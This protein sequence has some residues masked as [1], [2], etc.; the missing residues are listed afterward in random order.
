MTNANTNTGNLNPPF[1]PA[2]HY[3]SA[4]DVLNDNGLSVP[5]KR[6]ILSSWASDI[7]A[8]ESCPALREIPG[9]GHTIGLADI[10]AALRKLDGDD[11]DPPR[12]GGLA[13][14]LRR[15]WAA[16]LRRSA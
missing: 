16:A 4:G 6:I 15:P 14:R 3:A 8:V 5:E 9:M 13:M 10:V 7:Y 1:H 12:P 2:A 11:D